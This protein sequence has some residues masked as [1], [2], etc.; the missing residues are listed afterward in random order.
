MA[1]DTNQRPTHIVVIGASAGGL[2]PVEALFDATPTD[3]GVA[4]VV[5]Q[6]L[7]PDFKSLMNQLLARHSA[8]PIER[9]TDG[10]PLAADTIYLN[11]PREAMT[12]VDG[13][14]RLEEERDQALL[15]MPINTILTSCAEGPMAAQ[16][17]AVILSGTGSDGTK[18]CAALRA[19]G[20][21]VIVQEPGGAK[22]DGMPQSVLTAGLADAAAAP[23]AIPALLARVIEGERLVDPGPETLADIDDPM[24]AIYAIMRERF[25]TDFSYY[26][27]ET[28]ERRV[29][30]RCELQNVV[31]LSAYV[32]LLAVKADEVEALYN[33]VLIE[34]TAFFRDGDA[35]EALEQNVIAGLAETMSADNQVRVWVPGCA[36]GEEPYSIAILFSEYA[37]A[38]GVPLNLKIMA[39]DIHSRSLDAASTGT[40][41]PDALRRLDQARIDR[42]F[43]KVGP[44]Y[45]V[46]PALRRTVV[47]SPHNL[48][49][50]PPFTRV[51]LISCRN[52]LIY[53]NDVAQQKCLALFH[54]ALRKGGSLFLGPAETLGSLAS[55]FVTVDRRWRIFTKRRDVRLV[56]STTLLPRDHSRLESRASRHDLEPRLAR[57]ET[58]ETRMAIMAAFQ[59]LLAAH[60]PPGYLVTLDGELQHVFGDASRW[61]GIGEGAFSRKVL[62]LIHPDLRGVVGTGLDRMRSGPSIPFA[63]GLTVT[64]PQT[65]EADVALEVRMR[66]L[67]EKGDE[68][69]FILMTIE[70]AEHPLPASPLAATPDDDGDTRYYQARVAE[71]E[72]ALRS[73]EE[74]LQTT[75]EELETS[76]EELQATNEELMASNE[77]LQ[78]TNEELHSVNEELYTVSS[79]HQRKIE[80]LTEL[81]SDMDHLLKATEIG[82]VFLDE[83]LSIRRFTPAATRAFNL[84]AQD[85]GRPLD[86]VTYRFDDRD[87]IDDVRTVF[88]DR[89]VFEREVNIDGRAYLL[90]VLPY[91]PEADRAAGAVVTLIDID[92]L[93]EAQDT[94]AQVNEVHAQVLRDVGDYIVRWDAETS[95][96]A[97][98]NDVFAEM[99]GE[100]PEDLMGQNLRAR[101]RAQ[102]SMPIDEML[103]RMRGG[104]LRRMRVSIVLGGAVQWRDT[105]VRAIGPEGGAPLAFQA[106]GRDVT[107]EHRYGEALKALALL[108][109]RPDATTPEVETEILSL[110]ADF[111]GM[112]NALVALYDPDGVDLKVAAATGP[113]P[114]PNRIDLARTPREWSA[115]DALD[116]LGTPFG[117][118]VEARSAH[119]V[120]LWR[121][122]DV[123]GTLVFYCPADCSC[124]TLGTLARGFMVLIGQT[125]GRLRDRAHQE[126]ELARRGQELQLIFDSVAARIWYKDAHNRILR[127]NAAAATSMGLDVAAAEGADT[128]ELFPEMAKKY[129]DDDLAVI[130]SGEQM[131]G[132]VER[133]TPKGQ[134]E[135]WVRTDK[136]PYVDPVTGERR[137]LVVSS[138]ITEMRTQQA[139]LEELNDALEAEAQRFTTLYRATPIQMVSL[140]EDGEVS[141]VSE[142]FLETLGYK[143]KQVVGADFAGFFGGAS[144][145]PA[146]K[147]IAALWKGRPMQ[148]EPLKLRRK[149]GR[150]LE[151]EVSGTVDR[152]SADRPR[153]LLVFVDVSARNAALADLGAKNDELEAA[154]E[155]LARFA[156][157]ASH[158]LQEPLR[159]IRQF[160]GMLEEDYAEALTEDGRYY[161]EVMTGSAARMTRLVR[162]LLA[163]SLAANQS[164]EFEPIDLGDLVD[165]VVADL[166]LPIREA[167]AT[168]TRDPLPQVEGESGLLQQLFSNL[169]VNAIRYRDDDRP[170]EVRIA[171]RKA[172]EGIEITVSDNGVGFDVGAAGRIFDPFVRLTHK[173][174]R[175]GTGIGLAICRAACQR[176]GWT[177]SADGQVGKGSVFT[178][179]I[180]R[181]DPETS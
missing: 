72:K 5:V 106:T 67:Y 61:L 2:E 17:V 56:E 164:V 41:G 11:G 92:E 33:D 1:K 52:V 169:I 128:Y 16:T 50:D 55:E 121:G 153:A 177:I 178:I 120:P 46:T 166:E 80:E 163:Y 78:S 27:S 131:L 39:T 172:E 171:T 176:H 158:D 64:D 143:R 30:R 167:G 108:S 152:S 151:V 173:E 179:R 42:Y 87:F 160:A 157:A 89:E 170:P 57:R 105:V 23:D 94:L 6:H 8:M 119:A 62:E 44:Y 91:M 19:A 81:T 45:Q 138:D 132:I 26:K 123:V 99:E 83:G 146:R 168:V 97:Y 10:M 75:I 76:N 70:R 51:D 71:L 90:R 155:G 54:F 66:A 20:G 122:G 150:L 102:G 145:K 65:G 103:S 124:L 21:T 136:T 4:Y 181:R 98:C 104:D 68:A 79:E 82:T 113:A 36:S 43:E 25:G 85:V 139:R 37:R 118:A 117:E 101:R 74:S 161:L 35:F 34:V 159:K 47:F 63:R 134:P 86:H 100:R 38:F 28:I 130:D 96:I 114:V 93:R 24:A 126:H 84:M 147:A 22:F 53:L 58:P 49:R 127:L 135:S 111:L 156:H 32:A 110:G 174:K 18:G 14:F 3:L 15:N 13:R 125:V 77:E 129:H 31:T 137:L 165:A 133:Y 140:E 142:A 7:S 109:A 12:I 107:E 144:R 95:E 149:S 148:A 40:Y 116:V 112:P 69:G 175:T 9:V 88:E 60:A 48:L 180:P 141:E 115:E 29:R 73:T 59:Q 162:D 154:N